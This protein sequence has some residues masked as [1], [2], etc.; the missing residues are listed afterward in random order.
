MRLRPAIMADL[1]LLRHWDTQPHVIENG[2]DPDFNDWDWE[3]ELP[4]DVTW[5]EFL[6]AEDE[7]QPIGF[8]QIID[9]RNEESHYWGDECPEHSRAIDIWIGEADHLGQG[10]GSQ[11]MR[12][13]LERC[14]AD[15]R[16]T[17]VLIDPMAT[18]TRAHRFYERLG[19][20][21]VGPRNFGPDHCHIYQ[22]TRADWR[23]GN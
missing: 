20:K 8:V 17:H 6:I 4:R 15:P 1:D 3:N 10:L 2:G 16:V 19:F 14:F 23:K 21:F 5:R 7:G 9:C 18:N 13:A 12:L 22:L 11:M